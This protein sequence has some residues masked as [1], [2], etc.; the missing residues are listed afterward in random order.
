MNV[1]IG[2]NENHFSKWSDANFEPKLLENI[3]RARYIRLRKIQSLAI[4]LI[5][6]GLDFF[7]F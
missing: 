3:E 6:D 1:T 4:P 7:S 2:I 5:I